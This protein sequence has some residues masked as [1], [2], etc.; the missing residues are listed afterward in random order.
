[1]IENMLRE[2]GVEYE[3]IPHRL[4]FSAQQTAAVEHVSG[5]I[6]AKT[7]IVTDGEKFHMLVLPGSHQVDMSLA[8]K[9]LGPGLRLA[10]EEEMAFLFPESELGAEPPFGSMY[11]LK[12]YVDGSLTEKE[13]I[14]FRAGSH[15]RSIKMRC[16]DYM[17]LEKPTVACFTFPAGAGAKAG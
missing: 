8:E 1:M 11:D 10:M 14:V 4:A 9:L 15:E 16:A 7:V 12:T 3:V 6:F 5:H 13:K 2:K 17:A